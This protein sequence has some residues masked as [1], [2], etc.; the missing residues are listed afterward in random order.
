MKAD[1][2][3]HAQFSYDSRIQAEAL[4]EQAILHHYGLIAITEH[5]DLMP[6]ELTRF[7]LPSFS[8]YTALLRSLQPQAAKASLRLLCGVEVGDWHRVKAFA[9][10]FLAQLEFDLKLGAVHFLSDH[11]NVAVPL[12]R[13][14]TAAQTEDYY[15]QN[16]QLV[17]G[18]DAQVLAHLGVYKRY[19]SQTPDESHCRGLLRDIFAV[20]I[21]RGIALEINFS[22]LR[23]PYGRLL[24]ETWQ[25]ELY[26]EMGGDLF[27]I[28]SDAH[29][30]QHFDDH[31]SALPEWLFS[32]Q[33]R[34]PV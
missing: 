10:D 7:G 20:L 27:S 4:I 3:I 33:V 30:L 8:K 14:L 21:E 15:R 26:R 5:L 28:G 23:K 11:T 18:C 19:Y 6:Y 2:H 25:I 31:Y 29:Q 17:Q 12:R 1:L 24:P 32:S 16:L 22:G 9:D 13:A 34:F